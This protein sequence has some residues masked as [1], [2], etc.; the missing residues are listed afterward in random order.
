MTHRGSVTHWHKA[1]NR[2]KGLGAGEGR[3]EAG[4]DV[5]TLGACASPCE[6]NLPLPKLLDAGDR[7]LLEVMLGLK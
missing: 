1:R 3:W 6:G 4:G 5:R 2:S 7:S